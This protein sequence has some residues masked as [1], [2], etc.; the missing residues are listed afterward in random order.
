MPVRLHRLTSRLGADLA[1][2]TPAHLQVLCDLRM[3]EDADLDFK[4]KDSYTTSGPEGLDEL[5]KD[6]TAL[7]NARG[8]LIIVGIV[9]DSQGCAE[10]LSEVAVSDKKIGQMYN[11]L[12]SR[13]MPYLPDIWINNLE[14]AAVRATATC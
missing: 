12:R 4:G 13:V 7:A 10:S 6:V 14:S 11:G 8:G 9:E 2:L 1:E 3:P 5:A